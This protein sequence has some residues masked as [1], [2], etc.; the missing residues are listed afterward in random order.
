MANEII[1]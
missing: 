1:T